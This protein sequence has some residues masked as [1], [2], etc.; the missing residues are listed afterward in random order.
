VKLIPVVVAISGC[1][2]TVSIQSASA[3]SLDDPAGI[4]HATVGTEIRRGA[5]EAAA[6]A[7]KAGPDN[8]LLAKCVYA[9]HIQNLSADSGTMPFMLGLFFEGWLHAI[10]SPDAQNKWSA[11]RVA[12]DFFSISKQHVVDLDLDLQAVCRATE[13]DCS[14][15]I[16][17][18]GTWSE[19]IQQPMRIK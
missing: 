1:I 8:V 15:V 12:R 14:K 10:G 19:S 6:C 9:S 11:E 7:L 4:P 13:N 18:W 17:L 16:P 2:V 3:L 5:H